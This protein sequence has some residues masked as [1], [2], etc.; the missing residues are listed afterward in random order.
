[1]H[2]DANPNSAAAEIA[3][4]IAAITDKRLD[5]FARKLAED[6]VRVASRDVETFKLIGL[7]G[8]ILSL[9]AGVEISRIAGYVAASY[10][11]QAGMPASPQSKEVIE[12]CASVL[13][14]L[15]QAS[16]ATESE[17]II[18]EYLEQSD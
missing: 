6:L 1:M 18:E 17:L 12:A 5:D 15:F 11:T 10:A 8:G 16:I 2:Q 3:G 13:T 7:P 4:L 9:R 14:K